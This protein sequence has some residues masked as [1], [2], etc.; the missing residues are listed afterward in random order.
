MKCTRN[1]ILEVRHEKQG[2]AGCEISELWLCTPRAGRD[3]LQREVVCSH[4]L[5]DRDLNLDSVFSARQNPCSSLFW[6]RSA[7]KSQEPN[8]MWNLGCHDLFAVHTCPQSPALGTTQKL[9]TVLCWL[10][11]SHVVSSSAASIILK[12]V[13]EDLCKNRVVRA[14][15]KFTTLLC[16]LPLAGAW[17]L[18]SN[19]S[20]ASFS[21]PVSSSAASIILQIVELNLCRISSNWVLWKCTASR[22][23][24]L[25]GAADHLA[26]TTWWATLHYAASFSAACITAQWEDCVLFACCQPSAKLHQLCQ[27]LMLAAAGSVFGT[28]CPKKLDQSAQFGNSA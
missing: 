3:H 16:S 13:D 11:F 27:E 10:S 19:T 4:L 24:L 7:Q 9:S 22:L 25:L 17:Y 28:I 6:I 26:S 23:H 14:I 5:W 18:T 12:K 1:F 15:Q 21:Y 20:W 8:K 2:L